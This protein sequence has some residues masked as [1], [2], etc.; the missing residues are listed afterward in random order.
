MEEF[1]LKNKDLE[2][3]ASEAEQNH[4][5]L[6]Q[7]VLGH[8]CTMQC[9]LQTF[10][11]SCT[12]AC[13]SES[14]QSD[15]ISDLIAPLIDKLPVTENV[16]HE[17]EQQTFQMADAQQQLRCVVHRMADA[18]TTLAELDLI[19]Q[20]KAQCEQMLESQ[21]HMTVQT[22]EP[23]VKPRFCA[24]EVRQYAFA[25]QELEANQDKARL[26]SDRLAQ[27]HECVLD[28]LAGAEEALREAESSKETLEQRLV[29]AQSASA[30]LRLDMDAATMVCRLAC[31]RNEHIVKLPSCAWDHRSFVCAVATGRGASD[32]GA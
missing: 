21:E 2:A 23:P 20:M 18:F 27:E 26:D 6:S 4:V 15:S 8:C 28:K 13:Q 19:G 24:G 32:A 16:D 11:G 7:D 9:A 30:S 1:V 10:R 22:T 5:Q 29:A 14:L 12:D 25:L 3:R 17:G 31:S